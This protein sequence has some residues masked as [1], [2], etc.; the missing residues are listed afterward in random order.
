MDNL[1]IHTSMS[2]IKCPKCGTPSSGLCPNCRIGAGSIKIKPHSLVKCDCG[3]VMQGGQ[4]SRDR[5]AV[6]I[7]LVERSIRGPEG[8]KLYV[9]DVSWTEQGG[10]FHI[11]ADV[12]GRLQRQCFEDEVDFKIRPKRI[13]CEVCK[14]QGSGYFEAVIQIR[15]KELF[16]EVDQEQIANVMDVKGGRDI[17]L[18]SNAHARLLTS[19][20]ADKGYQIIH[21]KTL[22]TTKGTKEVYRHYY[23]IK[24]APF[25]VGWYLKI[26]FRIGRVDTI[27]R[28][29]TLSDPANDKPFRV[30]MRKAIE[31]EVIAKPIDVKSAIVTEIRPDGIQIMDQ[32][33]FETYDLPKKEGIEAGQEV[34]YIL[35]G[36]KRMLVF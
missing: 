28:N 33:D 7:D 25:R 20:L 24:H 17:Y 34:R 15:D 2:D 3:R 11:H 1:L 21:S 22:F 36:K 16:I 4:W 5:K 29:V 14:K 13:N 19:N 30:P 23:S 26:G 31:G 12:H 6:I 9:D 18:I 35:H 32:T 10:M 27:E 8:V